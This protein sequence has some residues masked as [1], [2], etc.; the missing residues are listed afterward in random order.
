MI[1]GIRTEPRAV[2]LGGFRLPLSP[3]ESKVLTLIIKT[4]D[5]P[6]SRDSIEQQLYGDKRRKSNTVEVAVCRLRQKL[7]QHGYRINATR[8]RGYTITSTKAGAA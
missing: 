8:G 3:T 6:I 5:E 1:A 2:M 4:G 7:A